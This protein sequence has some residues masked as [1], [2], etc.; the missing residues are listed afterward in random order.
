[1]LEPLR[2]HAVIHLRDRAQTAAAGRL[3]ADSGITSVFVIDHH[4]GSLS[5]L[6]D[7]AARLRADFGF[8]VGVNALGFA[9]PVVLDGV[10]RAVVDGGIDRAPEGIWVDDLLGGDDD[11][12]QA[13][14]AFELLGDPALAQTTYFGGVAF[15]YTRTYT[16]DP[17]RAASEAA[18]LHGYTD[19]VTTSGPGTNRMASVAK[20]A[21]MRDALGEQRLALASGVAPDNIARYAPYVTDVLVSSSLETEPYSGVFV[22]ER[23]TSL[24]AAAAAC[25]AR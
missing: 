23:V 17:A 8:T 4:G 1:M 7:A 6:L 3:L 15:K 5:E 25:A 9:P 19:V 21:S 18:M 24:V 13:A 2:V 10:R 22:A 14:A 11:V 20:V 16:D 12:G